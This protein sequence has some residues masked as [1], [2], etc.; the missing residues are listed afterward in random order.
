MRVAG[1]IVLLFLMY[2]SLRI[3]R[4]EYLAETGRPGDLEKAISL[5]PDNTRYRLALASRDLFSDTVPRSRVEEDLR[6]ILAQSPRNGD[7]LMNLGILMEVKGDI[8]KAER[9]LNEAAVNDHTYKPSW[10]LANFYVRTN[11]YDK[12]WPHIRRVIEVTTKQD[13]LRFFNLLAVYDLCW[14][15][16]ADPAF[17][18]SLIPERENTLIPYFQ[19]IEHHRHTDAAIAAFPR[20]IRFANAD[21]PA[22]RG[23]FSEYVDLLFREDR[24]KELVETWNQL[25]AKHIIIS[26]EVH[27]DRA[28]IITD[29]SFEMPLAPSAFGWRSPI[30]DQVHITY[31]PHTI[32]F[33][34]SGKQPDTVVLLE[35]NFAILPGKD[36]FLTWKAN[37]SELLKPSDLKES[38]IGLRLSRAK[39]DI[40]IECSTFFAPETERGCHFHMPA[41]LNGDPVLLTLRVA[42]ERVAGSV[43]LRGS[44]KVSG[45]ELR[46]SSRGN[47]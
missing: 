39:T 8:A 22:H 17:L 25:V 6:Q 19:Y 37:G 10:T 16:E 43:R 26:T 18:L 13:A 15:T 27:P 31:T 44:F 42:A 32:L 2:L 5:D 35:K 34:I 7:A 23:I 20:A 14:R 41:Q 47:T 33:D 12:M 38:G 11:Q 1:T 4:V 24:A 30:D 40:P 36:Y 3:A 9:Y 46:F 45:F 29:P 28:A 21:V